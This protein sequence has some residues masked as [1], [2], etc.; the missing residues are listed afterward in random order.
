MI[1]C[2]QKHEPE[3]LENEKYPRHID[4]RT[5]LQNDSG[6][7]S[8]NLKPALALQNGIGSCQPRSCSQN[9]NLTSKPKWSLQ[10]RVSI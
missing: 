6:K 1:E 10:V 5:C 8:S 4:S 9:N 7:S 2:L 3:D